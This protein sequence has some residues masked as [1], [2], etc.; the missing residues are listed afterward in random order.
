VVWKYFR[1]VNPHIALETIQ[2]EF[3]VDIDYEPELNNDEWQ[4]DIIHYHRTISDY[5]QMER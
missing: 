2:E 3:S 4:Y 5:A 1:S